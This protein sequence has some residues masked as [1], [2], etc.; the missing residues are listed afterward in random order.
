MLAVLLLVVI[1]I[2]WPV[3]AAGWVNL[4]GWRLPIRFHFREQGMNPAPQMEDD[5]PGFFR[6]SGLEKLLCR[7]GVWYRQSVNR[8][9]D[10]VRGNVGQGSPAGVF[11]LRNAWPSDLG[12]DLLQDT[13]VFSVRVRE[14][15]FPSRN[16]AQGTSS[17]V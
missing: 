17:P 8:E 2:G 16:T 5:M 12:G 11:Y 3:G 9:N 6:F 13:F 10:V 7:G 14:T 15:V 1:E 4:S